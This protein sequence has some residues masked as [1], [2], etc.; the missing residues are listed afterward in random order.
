PVRQDTRP[1][2]PFWSGRALIRGLRVRVS[3]STGN[4]LA[5]L[6]SVVG[7]G[8]DQGR[9]LH[10]V[11]SGDPLVDRVVIWTRVSDTHGTR[12][13]QPRL[14][15]RRRDAPAP[16]GRLVVLTDRDRARR[17]RGPRR[18]LDG[19]ARPRPRGARSRSRT[20]VNR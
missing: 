17:R 15:R 3:G 2:C 6:S 20:L 10:G 13:R 18:G 4:R 16:P 7:V 14:R 11:A 12:P 19:R 8:Q 1:E 5:I 9:F